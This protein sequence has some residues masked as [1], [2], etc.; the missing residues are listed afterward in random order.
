M[1][2]FIVLRKAEGLVHHVKREFKA[3]IK[4]HG[5]VRIGGLQADTRGGYASQGGHS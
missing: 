4:G 2:T 1:I 3:R 5:I